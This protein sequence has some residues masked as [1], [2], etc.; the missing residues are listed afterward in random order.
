MNLFEQKLLKPM[1]IGAEGEP[2]DNPDYIFELKL[3]GIRCIAYLDQTGTE[4]RNKRNLNVTSIY[5]ELKEIHK[6]VDNRCILDGEIIVMHNGKPDF[7]EVKRRALMS[8]RLK[9]NLAASKLPVSFIAFDILYLIDEQIADLSLMKR[10]AILQETVIEENDKLA[11]SRYIEEKGE[12]LY[13]LAEQKNLE[14]I[15]AKLK[16]SR[17]ILDKRTKDW[18]KIKNLLDDDFVVCGYIKKEKGITSIIL[19]QY[20]DDV[21]IYKGHV[22]LGVSGED[23]RTISGYEKIMES[24]FSTLP[25]GSGHEQ[26]VWIRPDLVCTVKFMQRTESGGMR[27]PVFKG[28]RYDKLPQECVE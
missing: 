26:A 3:D 25:V 17:Y 19:G 10:K 12:E 20:R 14:G 23:F 28:L 7:S 4:L 18:I 1:L 6:Q 27:Q 8:N 22:T 13:R 2:F 11:I 5:P 21:L 15:V 24:P 9:I 16:E